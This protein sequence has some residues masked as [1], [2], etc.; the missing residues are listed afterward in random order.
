MT[1]CERMQKHPEYETMPGYW[2]RHVEAIL[3]VRAPSIAKSQLERAMALMLAG[4]AYYADAHRAAYES[5]I[6]E[7]GVLGPEWEAIGK[8]LRGL[9]NGDLG[10]LDAGAIDSALLGSLQAEGFKED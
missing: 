1:H 3:A 4:W 8:A 2:R 6:G 5:G 7:D 9:L 10:R